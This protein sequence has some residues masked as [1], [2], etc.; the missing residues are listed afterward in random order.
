M[1]KAK[2]DMDMGEVQIWVD[3]AKK[4]AAEAARA[5]PHALQASE[6]QDEGVNPNIVD[7]P[8][9][10]DSG[11]KKSKMNFIVNPKK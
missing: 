5:K 4:K 11:R 3:D 6:L 7:I 8:N 9:L 2:G 10:H 1:I